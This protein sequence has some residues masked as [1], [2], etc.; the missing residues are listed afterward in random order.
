MQRIKFGST[1]FE[2]LYW[3][4]ILAYHKTN[5]EITCDQFLFEEYNV[6][7]DPPDGLVNYDLIFH[8]EEL[9][10]LLLMQV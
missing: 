2:K 6:T 3:F 8:D 9:L 4:M 7:L 10:F 1:H 5:K